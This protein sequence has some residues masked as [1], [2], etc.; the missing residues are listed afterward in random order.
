MHFVDLKR[1]LVP[2]GKDQE[3]NLDIGR[4]W[5]RRFA[6]WL[7]WSDLLEHRRVV[8]LA[9]AL[10]GKTEEFRHQAEALIA[11]GKA[12]FFVRIEDLADDGFEAALDRLA[13]QAFEHWRDGR[14]SEEAYFFLDSVDEARL[15]H[16]SLEKALRRFARELDPGLERAYIYVSCRVSD[17]KGSDDRAAVE[18]LLPVRERPTPP[19]P[20]NDESAL[21]GPIFGANSETRGAR[22]AREPERKLDT[23]LVVQ[24]VPL[25]AEQRR[26]LAE[27]AGVARPESFVEAIERN[28]LDAL[29]DRPGDLL[30]LAEYWKERGRF[31]SLAEMTEH[32]VV[33]KLAERD[34][35]RS[36]S[37]DLSSEKARAGAERLAAALTLGKSFTL[38]APGHDPDPIL[39]TGA[40]DPAR[41][42]DDWTDAERNAL[43]R[44]G[45][46]A[47]ST[48]G[49]IRFHHRGTQE[50]LTA[51][52]LGRL[53]R[54]GCPRAAVWDLIFAYRYGIETL[55]PSLHATAAW[56][57]LDHP[58]IRD[59][60]IQ[61]E[62]LVLLRDGDSR[63]LPL[64]AKERLLFTYAK[65]H[66][67]GEIS[68][69]SLDRRALW[70]FAM[71]ELAE[72]IRRSWAINDRQ[73]FRTDLLLLV[74]E[75][76]IHACADLARGAVLDEMAIDYQRTVALQ[77]LDACGDSDGLAAA[78]Q[79]L[80]GASSEGSGRLG[81]SFAKVLFP[82]YLTVDELLALIGR[83]PAPRRG[84]LEGFGYGLSELWE[85][86]PDAAA[87]EHFMIGLTDLSLAPPFE[88][89]YRRISARHHEFA[90]NLAP[91][92]REAVLRLMDAEPSEG[93]VRLLMAVERA[94]R[95][96]PMDREEPPLGTLVSRNLSL[97][98]KLFWADVEETRQNANLGADRPA[99]VFDVY[100]SG[101]PLWQ[102]GTRDLDW[103]FEDFSKRPL[104]AD[105][106]IALSGIITI[107]RAAGR[108]DTEV[109]RLRALVA[110]QAKL[111]QYLSDCLTPAT[112]SDQEVQFRREEQ[113]RQKARDE[114]EREAK[115]SWL[116][117][118]DE[119]KADPSS[120]RDPSRLANWSTGAVR[121][122]NLSRWLC[123]KT[124]KDDV[125]A[126]RQWRLLEEGFGWSVAE[127]FRDGMKALWRVTV[128]ERP[129]HLKGGGSNV[130]YTTIMSL[131]GLGLEAAEDPDWPLDLT[132]A[133][134][135][136]AA[137]HAC[138]SERG[139]PNW[140][141]QLVDRH[142]A[143]T[144][145]ILRKTLLNEWSGRHRGSPDF[146][147]HYAWARG[148]IP[149][150]I[151]QIL[152]EVIRG[153]KPKV[154]DMLDRGLRVLRRIEL[155]ERQR[156]QAAAFARRRLRAA[157]AAGEDE[158]IRS[159]LAMLFLVDA[160]GATRELVDWLDGTPPTSRDAR[161]QTSL[162]ALFG[163][164][165]PAVGALASLSVA[166]LEA[167]VRL[168]YRHVR[169]QDDRVHEGMHTPD[170]RDNAE[171]AR[172]ALLHAL[173]YRP[174]PDAYRAM[175]MLAADGA[176]RTLAIRLNELAHGKAERDS[177]PP[178]WTPADVIAF[179]R[180]HIA[181][182]KTGEALL[183]VVMAVLSDIQSSFSQANATSRSL[184]E[185]AESEDEVQGWL[186]EQMDL[187]SLGRFH[188]YREAHVACGDKP[189]I[190]VAS[191]AAQ[192]E[193]AIEVKHSGMRWTIRDLERALTKQLAETYLKPATRRHG[194]LVLSHHGGRTWRDPD[195][196]ATLTFH[197]L[198]NRLQMLAA[199]L[200]RNKFGPVEVRTFGIDAAR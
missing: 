34:T 97:Q 28:G 15:N 31:G 125:E 88:A 24:L 172:T 175:R 189:D 144:L 148:P 52:W 19:R 130:K 43:M 68:N 58:D 93:L 17:W 119:L 74:R 196:Q 104:E 7:D 118:R 39:V 109:P 48:Y 155:S 59:E 133:E 100:I 65:R 41:V 176:F 38:R 102:L 193:V 181:P 78:G 12:A 75:G 69:D 110:G 21:L 192:V 112:E 185:R 191:T 16:K 25:T 44:R 184:L 164:D 46:F 122:Y 45:V 105:K 182:A 99:H 163:R 49:R 161:A 135:E 126:A 128:P 85:L 123:G 8:L 3:T 42:L 95:D 81:P 141:E 64:E 114:A 166:S 143:I 61:H 180:R 30:D 50:Y 138:L 13:S 198:I 162:G 71:P 195:T 57:A 29:A 77:A 173:L 36:D 197:N 35:H 79:W 116:R 120:L 86:C 131:A 60:V 101:G 127:A 18:R 113:S 56:L 22:A 89:K 108:L 106:R 132:T 66:A 10:S 140:I 51:R 142:P 174:G 136:R 117:F 150:L 27:A 84:A 167:L 26:A 177:E 14:A 40:L 37:S 165:S 160:D 67:D 179:E 76:V 129:K 9:E 190:V 152:F 154:A 11:Q 188:V 121:L 137:Q 20:E 111:G 107:M 92:A 98:R 87:R 187:R 90:K 157:R 73:D 80:K 159:Y 54:G 168:A 158:R 1:C 82:R 23:L 170:V 153:K 115:A 145:P 147:S 6:N 146:L 53:L 91:L 33:R 156:C 149:P 200:I 151:Q 4:I 5:G 124:K 62:P 134:A 103:L 32:G 2:I 139:C 171:S 178:A 47:P 199:T 94:E 194:V 70:M 183:N 83:S 72:A 96:I 169:P 55:V 186:A 63:S